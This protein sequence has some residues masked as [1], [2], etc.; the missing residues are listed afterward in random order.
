MERYSS[1]NAAVKVVREIDRDW[2]HMGR[3]CSLFGE[4]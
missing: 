4:P 3:T 2:P 1:V